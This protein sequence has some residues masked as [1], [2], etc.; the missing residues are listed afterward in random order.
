MR[1]R[2]GR[3]AAS[4]SKFWVYTGH[5]S[6]HLN[7]CRCSTAS[8]SKTTVQVQ[9]HPKLLDCIARNPLGHIFAGRLNN[10]RPPQ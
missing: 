7:P 3:G 1:D 2:A 6:P 10:H 8:L 4:L 5:K 9:P